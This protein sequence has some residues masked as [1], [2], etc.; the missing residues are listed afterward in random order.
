MP[1]GD[2]GRIW[3][4]TVEDIVTINEDIVSEYP[5]TE[6]GVRNHGDIEFAVDHVRRVGSGRTEATVHEKA[7]NL[8]RL[9]TANHPF[10]DGN[11]RT[12]LDVTATFY[13]FNG[14]EFDYD[15]EIRSILKSFATDE[16]SVDRERVLQYFRSNTE[17]LDLDAAIREWREDLVQQGL[18]TLDELRDE[19]DDQSS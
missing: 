7:F 9:L 15:H 19:S 1:E 13:F 6:P 10:V 2:D 3:H 12:A 8:L 4:P 14:F 5:E 17:S 16:G 11:K 18:D